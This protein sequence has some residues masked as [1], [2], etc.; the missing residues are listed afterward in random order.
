MRQNKSTA[1][2]NQREKPVKEIS[3]SV[4]LFTPRRDGLFIFIDRDIQ[5]LFPSCRSSSL[6]VGGW[7]VLFELIYLWT[8][9]ATSFSIK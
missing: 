5:L 9:E 8:R 7:M 4:L 6:I 2:I 1:L 3:W